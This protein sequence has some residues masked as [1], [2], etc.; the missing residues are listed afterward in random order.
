M[1]S[2]NSLVQQCCYWDITLH[3]QVQQQHSLSLQESFLLT[4]YQE[5]SSIQLSLSLFTLWEGTSLRIFRCLSLKF[6][7]KFVE[8]TL[9]YSMLTQCL[10]LQLSF[11][12]LI[13]QQGVYGMVLGRSFYQSFGA[14]SSSVCVYYAKPMT[15]LKKVQME[16]LKQELL[17]SH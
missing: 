10:E 17:L 16:C 9:V 12:H 3:L 5:G 4:K 15:K 6:Q 14:P 13:K 1:P 2:M 7:L 8:L 11:V